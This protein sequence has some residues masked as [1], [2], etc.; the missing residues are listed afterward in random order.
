MIPTVIKDQL[1]L[2]LNLL[3]LMAIIT[4]AQ[5][6]IIN[7]MSCTIQL[8]RKT[9]IIQLARKRLMFL[10][11]GQA[12]EMFTTR[13]IAWV[14]DLDTIPN[15][16]MQTWMNGTKKPLIIGIWSSFT[17][18]VEHQEAWQMQAIILFSHGIIAHKVQ[19]YNM[20]LNK[21]P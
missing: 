8:I 19:R 5:E 1:K 4:L 14:R 3:R 18:V 7:Q 16:L 9:T 20:L 15:R 6:H 11:S 2:L 12:K 17:Q 21:G 10:H 13:W